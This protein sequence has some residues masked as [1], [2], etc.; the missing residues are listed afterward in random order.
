M[1]LALPSVRE[2]W[3]GQRGHPHSGSLCLSGADGPTPG[4][5]AVGGGARTVCGDTEWKQEFGHKGRP[6][7]EFCSPARIRGSWTGLSALGPSTQPS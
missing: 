5:A 3:R 6:P 7:G 2:G 4:A 1:R